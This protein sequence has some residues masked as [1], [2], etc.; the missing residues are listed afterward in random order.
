MVGEFR[1][2]AVLGLDYLEKVNKLSKKSRAIIVNITV[3][4]ILYV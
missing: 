3:R 4:L 2:E 1:K